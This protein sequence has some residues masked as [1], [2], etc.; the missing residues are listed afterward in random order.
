LENETHYTLE[1]ELLQIIS[2]L[3]TTNLSESEILDELN[4]MYLIGAEEGRVLL[5]KARSMN[6]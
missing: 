2:A 4:D 3:L 6:N 1:A 5:E